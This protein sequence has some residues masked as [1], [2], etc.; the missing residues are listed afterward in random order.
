MHTQDEALEILQ[1]S[2]V[3]L[4]RYVKK[5]K[6]TRHKQGRR[7]YYDEREVARLLLEI[8]NNSKKYRPDIKKQEPKQIPIKEEPKRVVADN[9]SILDDVGMS[10]L[11]T[12]TKQLKEKNIIQK[13]DLR[14][15]E[16]YAHS[17]QMFYRYSELADRVDCVVTSDNGVSTVH[18]YHK[19]AMDYSKKA[20]SYEK[21]LGLTP[22][23]R[24]R[25]K[26]EDKKEHIEASIFDEDVSDDET[27]L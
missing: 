15:L 24:Q 8:E 26:I 19:V 12:A 2:K 14:A 25:L 1:C 20:Q 10:I 18:P 9:R 13:T 27:I 21:E 5:G 23:S 11:M 7:S 22:L 17:L 16:Q 6:L 3:T 4:G